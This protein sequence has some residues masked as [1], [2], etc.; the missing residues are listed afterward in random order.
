MSSL[1]AILNTA[2]N[3]A[4][5]YQAAI[6]V[7]GQN[8]ANADNDDY[9]IQSAEL[10]TTSTVTS[11]GNIYG[12]GVTVASVARSVNQI[13]ENALNSEL[14]SQAA[15]EEAQVYMSSIEDLFSE[16]SVDSVNT[17]LDA[18]WS[19]WEDLSNNP[20]GQTE[21]NAVYD[22]GLAL[23]D[24]INAIEAALSDL[25]E[26]LDSEI[27]SAV[28]EVNSLSEQIAG[29]NLGIINAESTGG[30][31]NDLADERNALVSDLGERLDID[32]IVKEDGSYLINTCGLPLVEDGISYDL[33]LDQGSVYWTGKS[34]NTYDITDDI[35]GGAIAGWLEVRDVVIPETQ[36]EFD[37]LATN[38]IWT[39]NYQ[40]SQGAGQTY[41][42]GA[43]A[44]TYKA[45][46]SRTF[47]SLYYGDEIDYTK[48]FSMVIQDATDTTSE[49]QT[50]TMDMGISTSDIS[51]ITGPGETDSIYELTVIDEGTLGDKTVVQSSGT[52][53]GGVSYD[54][55]GI[56]A[57]M[58]AALAEQ[59]LTITNGSDTQTLDISDTGSGAG[60]SAAQIAEKLSGIDGIDA[61]AS[62]TSAYF[63]VSNISS[64]ADGDIVTFTLDVDGV[65]EDV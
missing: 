29:L 13:I 17:L 25:T 28:T 31:A 37:E 26:D 4:T 9:S 2:S 48:D 21:Q 61:Y 44:G 55:G 53:L 40:H 42:S 34:G 58:N 32:L 1:N 41:F 50:V 6:S 49:Y 63:D 18:Y 7:T 39:L 27:S 15:L 56:A 3:A 51:N 24:R 5:A 62:S 23:T 30:N 52:L 11:R 43:L 35:P 59:T 16:D 22:A 19:A 65:Q 8:I 33:N 14:S 38:L 57:A 45:G 64:A 54:S 60:R 12:T 46:D 20:S 47:D 36:A 10:A